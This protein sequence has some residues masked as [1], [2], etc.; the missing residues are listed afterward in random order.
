MAT[1]WEKVEVKTEK[2]IDTNPDVWLNAARDEL[3]K[4]NY[5]VAY[6]NAEQAIKFA[7]DAGSYSVLPECYAIEIYSCYETGDAVTAD[8]ISIAQMPN[9]LRDFLFKKPEYVKVFKGHNN[10]MWMPLWRDM[11]KS[12]I[13]KS[14]LKKLNMYEDLVDDDILLSSA[15]YDFVLKAV[16]NNSVKWIKRLFDKGF[17]LSVVRYEYGTNLLMNSVKHGSGV[18][19]DFL[20]EHRINDINAKDNEGETALMYAA[21]DGKTSYLDT[22]I[23]AGA[24]VNAKQNNDKTALEFASLNGHTG[25]VINLLKAGAEVNHQDKFGEN[26]LMAAAMS[27]HS[28]IIDILIKAGA[29]VNAKNNKGFTALMVVAAKCSS[30]TADL[31]IKAGADVNAQNNESYTALYYAFA[32]ANIYVMET[33]LNNH[34]YPD[35]EYDHGETLL[36]LIAQKE[37]WK[38]PYLSMWQLILRY[39][40]D[41]NSTDYSGYTPLYYSVDHTWYLSDELGMARA[42]VQKGAVVNESVR[43]VLRRH[44]I[45]PDALHSNQSSNIGTKALSFFE[46]VL[47]NM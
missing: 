25:A 43:Y 16:E 7:N 2:V 6:D 10:S 24:D 44:N 8:N 22:L 27:D 30:N 15:T 34:A 46:R 28:S 4:K 37:H 39:N 33:L 18:V 1:T 38:S 3:N 21:F 11:V 41:V 5:G 13:S 26:A 12:W 31:L 35:I 40:P 17:D 47:R 14:N 36:H 29:D 20:I 42:L 45:E 19:F 23:K 32:N 9:G